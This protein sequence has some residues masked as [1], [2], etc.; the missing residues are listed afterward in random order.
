MTGSC[1]FVGGN[2]VLQRSKKQNMVSYFSAKLEHRTMAQVVCEVLWLHQ[3]LEE[4]GF[5]SSLPAKL[6]CE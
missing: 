6:W 2:L 3:L 5:K 1:I 4:I